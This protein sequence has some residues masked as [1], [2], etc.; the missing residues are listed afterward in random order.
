MVL[1]FALINAHYRSPIDMN[2][3]LKDAERNP[4]RFQCYIE[5][6]QNMSE[7]SPVSLP[8][9]DLASTL[10][11]ESIVLKRWVKDLLML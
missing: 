9:A 5:S 2:E 10:P 4:I 6:L 8:Q 3:T 7:Q 1:R 11:L